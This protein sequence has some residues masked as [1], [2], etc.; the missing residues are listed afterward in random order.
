MIFYSLDMRMGY[1]KWISKIPIK[2]KIPPIIGLVK[3]S[4]NFFICSIMCFHF[5]DKQK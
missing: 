3:N 2:D 1:D 5:Y 4:I